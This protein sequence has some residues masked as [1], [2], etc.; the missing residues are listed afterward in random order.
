MTGESLIPDEARAM[1][2]QVLGKPMQVE[3][4][5][6]EIERY[7]HAVGDENPLYFDSSYAREAGYRDVIAPPLFVETLQREVVPLAELR[8]DGVSKTSQPIPLK[9]T[10]ML[11]GGEEVDFFQ[12]LYP[13]DK[14]TGETRL[15]SLTEKAGRSGPFVLVVRETTY[16][17]QE[18]V[19]AV[20]IRNT[21][22]FL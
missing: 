19:V 11:A 9:V 17:N 13:G 14:L 20:K 6:K 10:R 7:A 3:V 22:I 16:T 2:G 4:L 21:R 8:E 18:G 15:V 1:V 12:P 5:R